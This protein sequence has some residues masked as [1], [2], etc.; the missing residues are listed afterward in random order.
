MS[1][2]EWERG[3]IK[4][5]A[6]DYPKVRDAVIA[7][8]NAQQDR[9]FDLANRTYDAI[10]AVVKGK[11]GITLKHLLDD[12]QAEQIA[13]Q[14][15]ISIAGIQFYHRLDLEIQEQIQ[16][17]LFPSGRDDNKML[18][19]KKKDFPKA[20]KSTLNFDIEGE[21][22]ITFNPKEK[23]VEWQVNENNHACDR[24]HGHP[25]AT[26]LFRELGR[27]KWTNRSGGIIYGNDEYNRDD[28]YD[29]AG[30]G[31][32]YIKRRFGGLGER[33]TAGSVPYYD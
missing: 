18:K 9:I 24:A 32:S 6:G 14:K 11:R 28:G 23:T 15:K 4:I 25:V 31:G 13:E 16:D 19:P 22:S 29:R 17:S 2:Y 5:P 21:A 1:R 30:G 8:Y 7:A 12:Y 10:S 3:S 33:A 26:A 27:V 20:N